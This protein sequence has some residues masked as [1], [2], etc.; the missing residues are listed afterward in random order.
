MNDPSEH[1]PVA[2]LLEALK[3]AAPSDELMR[4]LSAARPIARTVVVSRSAKIIAFIPRLSMAAALVALAGALAWKFLPGS[5]EDNLADMPAVTDSPARIPGVLAAA[6]GPLQSR[7]RLLGVEDLG[8]ARDDQQR[9]VR[10]VRARWLD[11][12]TFVQPGGAPPVR[13]ERVRE[14]IVPVAVH[15]Y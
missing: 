7:Q 2:S 5:A 10:F 14:E 8:I 13:Q 12:Q 15:T 1:D 4:R 11:D 6:T 3:P 9:P